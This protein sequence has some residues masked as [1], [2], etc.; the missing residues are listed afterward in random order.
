[1][2]KPI[3]AKVEAINRFPV[4]NNKKRTHEI[5]RKAGYYRRF[6]R[7]F[8]V[9]VKPLTN[10]LHKDKKFEWQEKCQVAFE[11][12][13]AMLMYKPVLCAP[14]FQKPFKLAVD[15]SDIGTGAVLL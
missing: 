5:F 1:M 2:I 10:L 8:S 9:I 12:V 7:D 15:A 14:N 4:P 6:C 13:K 11:K 3:T